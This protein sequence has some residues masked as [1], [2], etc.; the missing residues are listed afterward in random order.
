MFGSYK[1]KLDTTNGRMS[2][3][4]K[5]RESL[6]TKLY[7]ARPTD[8]SRCVEVYTADSWETAIAHLRSKPKEEAYELK[9]NFFPYA[10][11]VDMDKQGRIK[12][13][14]PLIE[15]AGLDSEVFVNGMDDVMEIWNKAVW[16]N[17]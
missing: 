12:I 3:P 14:L 6:G 13:P 8:G 4:S 16:D 9:R 5:Y 17:R 15:Y 1:A 11:D 7:M 10:F 2:I